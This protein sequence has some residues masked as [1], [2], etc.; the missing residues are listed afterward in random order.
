VVLSLL[1][2]LAGGDAPRAPG[3]VPDVPGLSRWGR[4]GQVIDPQGN[5]I[6][7]VR[8]SPGGGVDI[9]DAKGNRIGVGR[10]PPIDGSIRIYDPK[11]GQ[12]LYKIRN[13]R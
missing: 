1:L 11:T 4:H 5:R 9:Y 13:Y 8:P 12:P 6:G 10:E 3:G 7:V 2:A